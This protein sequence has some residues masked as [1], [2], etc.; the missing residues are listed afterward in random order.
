MSDFK[1]GRM[2]R[3]IEFTK[4]MGEGFS[5]LCE[6]FNF[7]LDRGM[8]WLIKGENGS[9]KTTLFSALVWCL[10][11]VNLKGV[12]ND[13]VPSWVRVRSNEF[14]GTRVAVEF[15]NYDDGQS[16]LIA[17]HIDFRG[18]TKSVRGKSSL[19]IFAK[20]LEEP[21]FLPE[22]LLGDELHKGD[23]QGYIQKVLGL[24]VK[25]FLN[26][27]LFGQRMKRLVD[28]DPEEKR[29]LFETLFELEF[30]QNAKKNCA[31]K[32]AQTDSDIRVRN[33]K[34]EG[35]RQ[36][37]K[38]IDNTIAGNNKVLEDFERVKRERIET[39]ELEI[40]DRQERYVDLEKLETE[41]NR[42]IMAYD[43][44][45]LTTARQELLDKENEID[46]RDL[47]FQQL[48]SALI[49]KIEKE[50]LTEIE[51][52]EEKKS[53]IAAEI[54]L[55]TARIRSK[56][57]EQDL[58][59]RQI[60]TAE[61]TADQLF[62]TDWSKKLLEQ[63][64]VVEA[65]DRVVKDKDAVY[66]E[67][68]RQ[69][70][71]YG[72]T[73]AESNKNIAKFTKEIEE[74]STTCPYCAQDLPKTKIKQTT[75]AIKAKLKTEK[76]VH[77]M[78]TADSKKYE[79]LKTISLK[80]LQD[81]E[82]VATTARHDLSI[83]QEAQLTAVV[84]YHAYPHL[85]Y[86]GLQT[87]VKTAQVEIDMATTAR[88]K[89]YEEEKKQSE[90]LTLLN[91]NKLQNREKYKENVEYKTVKAELEI[92]GQQADELYKNID[93]LELVR[94]E[95]KLAEDK[96]PVLRVRLEE[97]A[98]SLQA[99]RTRLQVEYDAKPPEL[100]GEKLIVDR[101]VVQ[102]NIQS[103]END[104]QTLTFRR[105]KLDWW[106]L[107]GYGAGGLK[108]FVFNSG[109]ELLNKS[110][111]KYASR[112]GVKLE[113][114]VDLTKA[115][116]PFVTRCYKGQYEIDYAE[117]SGGQ[118]AR[119]DVA[120]AFAMH[121]IV[122]QTAGFNILILD[123]VFENLD[124]GGIETVFDLIRTKAGDDRTVYVITHQAQIDALNCKTIDISLDEHENTI[125]A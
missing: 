49:Q 98:A 1:T 116:K 102:K 87:R 32:L 56:N 45:P 76:E 33:T 24:D 103:E 70:Q 80:E 26:S 10:F 111:E 60:A 78:L 110:V 23:Q 107:T 22:H 9:G 4:I 34:I 40:A 35:F 81:L 38:A 8:I 121:D 19:M 65:A 41:V 99:A 122:S 39:V 62:K 68:V 124:T 21:E 123:E 77:K 90:K 27:I 47:Y 86:A 55:L 118:K 52:V 43:S 59:A 66:Q 79:Q 42:V 91:K 112:L 18:T 115:S 100:N 109:L 108:A 101:E 12:N 3:R 105:E 89:Y 75:D 82:V 50:Y 5:S 48:E 54:D 84:D 113:F 11:K 73:I 83:L 69:V 106:N 117:F 36:E 95:A 53:G 61:R 2:S 20:R 14:R 85:D 93:M 71:K 37:L 97:S 15:D 44:L 119:L 64:K 17:R 13:R 92:L 57:D 28:S 96:L 29:K 58:L 16:Y 63:E 88:S 31:A 104:I 7:K 74:I 72:T 94:Q 125:I 67:A 6:P 25:T 120:T 46:T 30:I 114:S 51:T